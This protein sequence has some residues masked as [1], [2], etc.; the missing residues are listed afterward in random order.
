MQVSPHPKPVPPRPARAAAVGGALVALLLAA[1]GDAADQSPKDSEPPP[2]EDGGAA[3]RLVDVTAASGL[4][5]SLDR[6]EDG[7]Y[8]MPD[9]M[10]GG[11]ALFDADGDG[12][13]DIFL[14]HGRWRNGAPTEDGLGRLFLRSENGTYDDVS[15]QAGVVGPH[16]AMGV[17][18]GDIEGDGDNDLYV[19]CLGA[20]RLL[21]NQGDGRFV[22]GTIEAGLGA[23]EWGAS[24]CFV[25]Y[26]A[27][28]ALDLFVTNYLDFPVGEE[29]RDR[30]GDAEYPAP[31]NYDGQ[32]D[33]LYRGNGDGTF[34]DLSRSAGLTAVTGRG[35]GVAPGDW[36]DDGRVDLYVAND[37]Q[38]NHCWIQ[39]TA[40]RF[41]DRA[42]AMGLAVSGAG[43]AE[44]GMGIARADIDG[45]GREDLVLTHLAQETHTFYRSVEGGRFRDATLAAGLARPSIDLTGFGVALADLDLDGA[46]DLVLAHGRVLRGPVAEQASGPARWRPYAEPNMVLRASGDRFEPV[47]SSDFGAPVETSRG[48]A[49]GDVDGDGDVDVLLTNAS[50]SVRLYELEGPPAGTWLAVR[51]LDGLRDALGSEVELSANGR[52]QRRMIQ[53]SQGYLSSSEA[54]A[55]FGVGALP[56]G[57]ATVVVRWPG[58]ARESFMGPWNGLLVVRRGAG[59]ELAR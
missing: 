43:R 48:L 24:C 33:R 37:G 55:R 29:S 20:D 13:L 47:A 11:C 4:D 32:A 8:F 46:L 42:L 2:R 31:G 50:G 14:A 28:G 15:V 1:C 59:K 30:R 54:V 25:D 51:A 53:P 40:G 22:D 38:A 6:A 19:S 12:D 52:V 7:R 26:D 39:T 49:I 5:V 57:D 23:S 21:V 58:G 16:F 45:D 18:V 10:T 3:L 34:E 41:E 9:S 35:L 27:D 56:A 17:A 44:A 36:N